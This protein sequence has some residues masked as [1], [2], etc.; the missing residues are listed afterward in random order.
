MHELLAPLSVRRPWDRIL[1]AAREHHYDLNVVCGLHADFG[2]LAN[3][4]IRDPIGRRFVTEWIGDVQIEVSK[5]PTLFE[6]QLLRPEM[7]ADILLH[8]GHCF[9]FGC[10][11]S[12]PLPLIEQDKTLAIHWYE[13]AFQKGSIEAGFWLGVFNHYGIGMKRHD[14]YQARELYSFVSQRDFPIGALMMSS[15]DL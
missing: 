7:P 6:Q 15:W 12:P 2:H 1:E 13:Q 11:S 10:P 4:H 9:R 3:V 14:L 5:L 8:I